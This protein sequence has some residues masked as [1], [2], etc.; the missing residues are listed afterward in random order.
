M[1]GTGA[2]SL[3]P[4]DF[5]LFWFSAPIMDAI[6]FPIT[7]TQHRYHSSWHYCF[8]KKVLFL[9]TCHRGRFTCRFSILGQVRECSPGPVTYRLSIEDYSVTR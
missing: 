3:D 6:I 9:I 1:G 4:S 8:Y 2:A 5:I 7:G